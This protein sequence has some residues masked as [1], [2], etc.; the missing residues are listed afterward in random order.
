VDETLTL[1]HQ[2]AHGNPR[3]EKAL[4]ERITPILRA[5]ATQALTRRGHGRGGRR[6][7]RQ[8]VEDLV[9]MVFSVLFA[10]HGKLFFEWDPERG[11]SFDNYVGMIAD[12]RIAS[13][14]RTHHGLWPDEPTEADDLESSAERHSDIP[15]DPEAEVRSREELAW[16]LDRVRKAVTQR[17]YEVFVLLYVEEKSAE[18]VSELAGISVENVYAYKSRLS[19]LARRIAEEGLLAPE[20]HPATNLP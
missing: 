12:S 11:K 6:D 2:A 19:K 9:Q 1:V 14:L 15:L 17:V 18:E 3:A 10:N 7:V 13:T 16:L 8:E 20:A 5:R 4:I